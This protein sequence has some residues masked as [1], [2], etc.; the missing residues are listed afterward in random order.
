MNSEQRGAQGDR[1]A[2]PVL[3]SCAD[4]STG[5]APGKASGSDFV[6]ERV[7][8]VCYGSSATPYGDHTASLINA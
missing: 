7:T 2:R 8:T 3:V 5:A 4:G 6:V 1:T